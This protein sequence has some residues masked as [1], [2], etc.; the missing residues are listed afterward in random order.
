M[1]K[2]PYLIFEEGIDWEPDHW[3]VVKS[4]HEAIEALIYGDASNVFPISEE[5]YKEYK[6]LEDKI[7]VARERMRDIEA[8]YSYTDNDAFFDDPEY[9]EAYKFHEMWR[10]AHRM[11]RQL[12]CEHRWDHYE[13]KHTDECHNCW[14]SK[15]CES[16]RTCVRFEI[17][18]LADWERELLAAP[19]NKETE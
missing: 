2:Q 9:Q 12:D 7:A 18:P 4:K 15:P 5:V 6:Q 10:E 3:Y 16:N 8:P 1:S 11:N 17:E 14:L 19:T 13:F